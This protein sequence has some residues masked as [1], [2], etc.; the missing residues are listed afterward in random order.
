MFDARR[1]AT[2]TISISTSGVLGRHGIELDPALT[3]AARR[4]WPTL[5]SDMAAAS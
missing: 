1:P 5:T 2:S 3:S 4:A